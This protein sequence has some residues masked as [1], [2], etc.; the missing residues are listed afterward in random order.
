MT[1]AR[2]GPA[3]RFAGCAA[4]AIAALTAGCGN[5]YEK[6]SN[7]PWRS[8]GVNERPMSPRGEFEVAKLRAGSGPVVRTG[9]LVHVR[10]MVTT[11]RKYTT[12]PPPKPWPVDAW[13]W[14]GRPPELPGDATSALSFGDLG[15]ER[16]RS[17]LIGRAV[18]ERFAIRL[19]DDAQSSTDEI[20]LYA[21]SVPF[22]SGTNYRELAPTVQLSRDG[23]GLP[24]AEIEVLE[25][26]GARLMRREVTLRQWGYVLNLF[27]QHY[28]PVRR[29]MLGWSAVESRCVAFGH[30]VRFEI[31]PLYYRPGGPPG[32]TQLSDW[33]ASYAI[34][35]ALQW[36]FVDWRYVAA[37]L[38][39]WAG[40]A[41]A[42]RRAQTASRTP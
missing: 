37:L 38:T 39:A 18:G 13:L 24:S 40:F 7:E 17:A 4:A 23:M 29:G 27:E 34:A 28:G 16:V 14:T 30:S 31:G 42:R 12:A 33:T 25:A 26:C 21:L 3:R 15:S 6:A 10:L 35:S 2:I 22:E 1:A 19:P 9:D 36:G 20:P 41:T 5:L 11:P 32:G 8:V